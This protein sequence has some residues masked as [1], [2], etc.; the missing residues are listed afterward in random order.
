MAIQIYQDRVVP[1]TQSPVQ[2]ATGSEIT[3]G[4]SN[5]FNTVG[6]IA[7]EEIKLNNTA[8]YHGAY[9]DFINAQDEFQTQALS[10]PDIDNAEQKYI[11]NINKARTSFAEKIGDAKMRQNFYTQTEGLMLSGGK[12]IRVHTLKQK[13]DLAISSLDETITNITNKAI[14]TTDPNDQDSYF[15]VLNSQID[16]SVGNGIL[17]PAQ[18]QNKK[19]AIRTTF[20]RSN[21]I[22]LINN[23]PKQAVEALNGDNFLNLSPNERINYKQSALNSLAQNIQNTALMGVYENQ[24]TQNYSENSNPQSQTP[25]KPQAKKRNIQNIPIDFETSVDYMIDRWEGGY[26]AKDGASNKPAN[27]G[28]NQKYHPDVDVKNLTRSQAEKKH[29]EIWDAID[30]DNLPPQ[31]RY[32]A[33]DL[34]VNSG[35]DPEVKAMIKQAGNDP[36]KLIDLRKQKYAKLGLEPENKKYIKGWNNR[37]NEIEALSNNSNINQNTDI[38]NDAN[39]TLDTTDN[40]DDPTDLPLDGMELLPPQ[41]QMMIKQKIMSE[42]DN[43]NKARQAQILKIA[44]VSNENLADY[45]AQELQNTTDPNILQDIANLQIAAQNGHT[46]SIKKLEE[47]QEQQDLAFVKKSVTGATPFQIN[48]VINQL[49]D[50]YDKNPTPQTRNRIKVLTEYN[51]NAKTLLK[52]DPVQYA[53]DSNVIGGEISIDQNNTPLTEQLQKRSASLPSFFAQQNIT[54]RFFTEYEKQHFTQVFTK[55]ETTL[56]KLAMTQ[57]LVDGIPDNRLFKAAMNDLNMPELASTA[58]Y[59]RKGNRTQAAAIIDAYSN[60]NKIK[61]EFTDEN[62]NSALSDYKAAF[63]HAGIVAPEYD[64]FKKGLD[65]IIQVYKNTLYQ[66][67]DSTFNKDDFK[68][69]IEQFIGKSVNINGNKTMIPYDMSNDITE[70]L[71]YLTNDDVKSVIGDKYSRDEF[72]DHARFTPY[73]LSDGLY[74]ISFGNA[75][76]LLGPKNGKPFV[77]NL[78][79]LNDIAEKNKKDPEI[80]KNL[81]PNFIRQYKNTPDTEIGIMPRG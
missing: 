52:S 43:L 25:Q 5:V 57:E 26:V 3:Q 9:R 46:P 70:T 31:M 44:K 24:P 1:T 76:K 62:I 2:Q 58:Y 53:I 48:G 78:Y 23:N 54:P 11:T 61:I 30:A 27:M 71:D 74:T 40:H 64:T 60:K 32:I 14:N 18:A 16:E 45:T 34:A 42:R 35:A 20:D 73:K 68:N 6:K 36:Q 72:V 12:Q 29:R 8:A 33:F 77:V 21:I 79:E 81:R 49:T 47:L 50:E 4:L 63:T 67:G 55:A 41:M 65:P 66:N 19:N 10:D 22:N 69:I 7:D 13:N 56:D 39:T 80:V 38:N 15:A 17:T 28:I 37:I 59:L 75:G 51:E